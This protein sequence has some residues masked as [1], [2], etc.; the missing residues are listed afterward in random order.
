MDF[1]SFPER[2]SGMRDAGPGE[3][4][5]VFEGHHESDS[6]IATCLENGR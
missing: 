2:T 6:S 3:I 1:S 5:E 4:P